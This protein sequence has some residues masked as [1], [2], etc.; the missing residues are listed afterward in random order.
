M[1]IFYMHLTSIQIEI[2]Q[3]K[4]DIDDYKKNEKDPDLYFG[5]EDPDLKEILTDPQHCREGPWVFRYMYYFLMAV[6][7]SRPDCEWGKFITLFKSG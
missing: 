2:T 1:L 5:F 4:E 3:V 6:S 7:P